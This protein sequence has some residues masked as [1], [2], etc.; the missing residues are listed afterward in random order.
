MVG[1][2]HGAGIGIGGSF[3]PALGG[4]SSAKKALPPLDPSAARLAWEAFSKTAPKAASAVAIAFGSPLTEAGNFTKLRWSKPGDT[5]PFE[6]TVELKQG[7]PEQ[8]LAELWTNANKN[9]EPDRFYSVPMKRALVD[10]K[11]V[12]FRLDLPIEKI[13]NYR[14]TARFATTR[15]PDQKPHWQWVKGADIDDV[16]FRPRAIEHEAINMTEVHIGLANAPDYHG[17]QFATLDDLASSQPGAYNLER[18]AAEGVNM[19]WLM[20]PF[21]TTRWE[22]SNPEDVAGSPFA[23][24]DYFAI[25]PRLSKR[26]Q[27]LPESEV[28]P[29]EKVALQEFKEMVEK[30]HSLGIKVILDVAL[31]HVGHNF[32]FRDLF[33]TP[34]GLEVQKNNFSQVAVNPEQLAVIEAKLKDPKVLKYMEYLN[35]SFY[36]KVGNDASGEPAPNGAEKVEDMRVGGWGFIDW[37]NW[38]DSKQL[39]H[40]GNWSRGFVHAESAQQ[41]K[42]VD[43]FTRVLEFWAINMDIDGFRLD[44]GQGLPDEFFE[45]SLNQLQAK[46]DAYKPGK[47]VFIM[48]ED[49]NRNVWTRNFTDA[50][51]TAGW[52]GDLV[53]AATAS[54]IDHL[55]WVLNHPDFK[56]PVGSPSH[57]EQRVGNSFGN[58]LKA[59]ARYH[60]FMSLLGGP[61][62]RLMGDELGEG[63]RLYFKE[64]RGVP[65][66][67]QRRQGTLPAANLEMSR[68]IARAGRIK[69]A[70]PAL[71]T[72]NRARLTPVNGQPNGSIAALARHADGAD[73]QVAL[74][75]GNFH[76]TDAK[77]EVFRLDDATR[78]RIDPERDYQARDLMSSDPTAPRW[79]APRKGADLLAHGVYV[80]LAPYQ[81][82]AL[83]LDA[84]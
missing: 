78:A 59:A 50:I 37:L 9:D 62:M 71:R 73:G 28:E 77:E 22:G 61:A 7:A 26:A 43:W 63:E 23:A 30:A 21:Y 32:I 65:T 36:G 4:A 49:H 19:V 51:Q 68:T 52:T 31:N 33:E 35:P 83:A 41:N 76:N 66:L 53:Y 47:R 79:P 42:V 25:D 11:R 75:F 20:C 16:I 56:Q 34:A 64:Y 3:A 18:L 14:A 2:V 8:V 74:V 60:A 24:R 6:L 46:V 39:N 72:A 29:R 44:H 17:H 10:G 55:W 45:R 38:T 70:E 67:V 5:I 1:A 82:Q 80:R 12:T 40:G 57:D 69:N 58:D 48:P 27:A 13:G 81:I 84:V 15:G 54:N